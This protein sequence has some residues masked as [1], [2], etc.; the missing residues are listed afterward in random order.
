MLNYFTMN[1]QILDGR[2]LATKFDEQL[3]KRIGLLKTAGII[4]G[5]AILLKEGDKES[6][7]FVRQKEKKCELLGIEVVIET[8]PKE[9]FLENAT[10]IVARWNENPKMNVLVVQVPRGDASEM[11]E[12]I[13]LVDPKKDVDCLHPENIGL[14]SFSKPRFL[15]PTPAGIHQLLIKNKINFDGK[16]V[17]IIGRG[18][19]VG[20]P[21]ALL[22]LQKKKD[23]NATVT[24]C[25]R[26]T[27]DL[28]K[29]TKQADILVVAI[30]QKEFI[31][32]EYI[33]KGCVLVDVGIHK[34]GDNWF[35]DVKHSEVDKLVSA[36]TPVPG[37]VGPM[38][39]TML[40]SNVILSA[41][42][43]LA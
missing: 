7:I 41:E 23:A 37:G 39:V 30:G 22:L 24:V 26:H 16:H 33:N 28:A 6:A 19:L 4:P 17:V 9:G 43:L 3:S 20:K 14:L 11:R 5:L 13:K 8:L 40:L 10:K 12:V 2:K 32:K 38:T 27:K 35:G 34:V 1:P 31:G 21:L 25:H 29:H 18:N 15:P 36:V 42:N